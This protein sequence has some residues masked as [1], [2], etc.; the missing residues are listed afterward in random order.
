MFSKQVTSRRGI[1]TT[2][3]DERGDYEGQEWQTTRTKRKT[4]D[5]LEQ[6]GECLEPQVHD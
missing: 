3:N 6:N 1:A 2:Y 5:F 4:M